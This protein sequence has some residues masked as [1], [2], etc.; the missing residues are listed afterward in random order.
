MNNK[1]NVR[2]EDSQKR[3]LGLTV[4]DE[5]LNEMF[6]EC[7]PR[8]FRAAHSVLRDHHDSEDA[9]QDGLLLALRHIDQ[10]KGN[11]KFSTWLFS[12]IRNAAFVKLRQQRSHPTLSM[13]DDG[14]PER[15]L[16]LTVSA[17][18]G[19]TWADP[20]RA[21]ARV[22]LSFVFSRML[23]ELPE[24][25]RAIIRLCDLQGFSGREAAEQLGLTVAALKAQH[26]RARQ[27]IRESMEPNVVRNG[28]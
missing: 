7:M 16:E 4:R 1:L 3:S 11:S 13:D 15:D 8:L 21:Y 26:H 27:A 10:F 19:D 6:D 12:I 25:Y 18:R 2:I 23:E 22:E 28:R 17:Q 5:G 9:L 20:E 14:H 24:N